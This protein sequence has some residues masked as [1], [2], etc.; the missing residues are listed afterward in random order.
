[1]TDWNK[2]VVARKA[3]LAEGVMG[4]ELRAP[5]GGE[6]PAFT[7]G[8]HIAVRTPAGLERKYSLSNDPDERDHYQLGVKR[9][10]NGRGGSVDFVDRVT[11]G[12]VVEVSAP[13]NDFP[14]APSKAG[15]ILIAGGIGITPIVSMARHLINTGVGSFH[16]YYVTRDAASTAFRDELS[17]PEF[18]GRV[19]IHHDGGDPSKAFDFW[20]VLES[21]RGQ[22]V[23]CCG[24]RGLMDAVRDMTGHWP[25]SAIHFEA[26]SE[27]EAKRPDDVAFTVQLRPSGETLHVPVGVTI[28]DALRAAGHTLASSCES[29]TCGTCR[30][31]LVSGE[32]DHRDLALTEDERQRYIM[33]CVSRAKSPQLVLD[34]GSNL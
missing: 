9:D 25:S 19:T 5:D 7:P 29:G 31:L 18:R 3:P 2:L 10:P 8:A 24:P 11:E 27:A 30:T 13:R 17:S 22:H 6:L 12:D 26:F 14:L 1:M 28:L 15:Y 23:Y 20:P 32:A 16:V 33:I 34:L 21:P 4:F